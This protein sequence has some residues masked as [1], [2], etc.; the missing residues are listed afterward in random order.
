MSVVKTVLCALLMAT[1]AGCTAGAQEAPPAKPAPSAKP[2]PPA[3]PSPPAAE[4]PAEARPAEAPPAA[5]SEV[6]KDERPPH[7][8][9]ACKT[10]ADCTLVPKR[11]CSC[12][13]C[14]RVLRESLNVT[15]VE[16]LRERWARRRCRM[17]ACKACEGEWVGT[18]AV[19][20]AGQ[21]T[22]K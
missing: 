18:R 3:K 10:D 21:C 15:A 17:P 16:R 19:C 2:A 5:V 6:P 11:P 7:A 8:T 20:E 22:T 14:G 4:A 12:P 1:L 13:P 9:R